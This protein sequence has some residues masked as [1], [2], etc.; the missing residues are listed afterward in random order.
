MKTVIKDVPLKR[1]GGQLCEF[2]VFCP[3]TDSDNASPSV[4]STSVIAYLRQYLLPV[5]APVLAWV[6]TSAG[7]SIELIDLKGHWEIN[8]L[9][10]LAGGIRDGNNRKGSQDPAPTPRSGSRGLQRRTNRHSSSSHP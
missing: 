7:P 10:R 9:V 6:A 8:G 2:E 3:N 1:P 4:E 5:L